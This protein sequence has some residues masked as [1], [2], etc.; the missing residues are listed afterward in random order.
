MPVILQHHRDPDAHLLDV[1][2]EPPEAVHVHDEDDLGE[3]ADEE[4]PGAGIGVNQ[5]EHV[6]ARCR[7]D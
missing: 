1:G 4:A 2:E 7:S 5:G 3:G 6:D